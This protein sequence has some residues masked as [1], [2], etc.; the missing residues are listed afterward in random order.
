VK[1]FFLAII[2]L[3]TLGARL[4]ASSIIDCSGSAS[5]ISSCVA[6]NLPNF[7]SQLDWAILSNPTFNFSSPTST[8]LW[9]ANNVTPGGM[10]VSVSGVGLSGAGEGLR[11]AYNLGTIFDTQWTLASAY[12]AAG[13][14]HPSHFLS[15][16][17]PG[18]LLATIQAD[19]TIHLLGMELNGASANR[20]L[21]LDFSHGF[22]NLGF[23][24]AASV[25]PT[26]S[27]RLQVFAGAGGTGALL[28]DVTFNSLSGGGTCSSLLSAPS[29]PV[30][31]NDA[32]FFVASGFGNL[33]R[34]AL[35]ST[36]DTHGFYISNL[37]IAEQVPG[38]GP[39]V[40]SGCGLVLLAIGSR[41]WRRI[42]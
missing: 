4:D 40:L 37:L 32:P 11:L 12:P 33:G 18:A 26:F 5:A 6:G 30:G 13:N 14:L 22:D 31:C 8:A 42:A 21:L 16:S 10:D 39:M 19:P 27:L 9:T 38:P 15:T 2:T 35:I 7:Q 1:Q 24:A 23:Y 3:A 28:G 25:D 41:K 17:N 34:S 29:A 20:Q 36:S